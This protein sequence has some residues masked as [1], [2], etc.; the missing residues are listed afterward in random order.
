MKN[1]KH[2]IIL[3]VSFILIFSLLTI[4]AKSK[5]NKNLKSKYITFLNEVN[6]IMTKKEKSI[7]YALNTEIDR[8]EFIELFWAQRDPTPLTKVNEFKKK[9][10]NRLKYADLMFGRV[11]GKPGWAT[12]RGRYYLVLGKPNVIDKFDGAGKLYPTEVWFYNQKPEH[13][14]PPNFKLVFYRPYGTEYKLY[15]PNHDGPGALIGAFSG[16]ADDTYTAYE[17][18]K[19]WEPDLASSAISLI[20]SEKGVDNHTPPLANI[21]LIGNIQA[22]PQR[23]IDDKYVEMYYKL[24]YKVDV[25]VA[26]RYIKSKTTSF[27][28]YGR[29]KKM[30]FINFVIQP[31]KFSIEKYDEKYYT[32]LNI[33]F[34]LYEKKTGKK[35][36]TLNKDQYLPMSKNLIRK[37]KRKKI[38]IALKY[39]IIPG[40]GLKYLLYVKNLASKEYFM[41]EAEIVSPKAK[42]KPF[43][44]DMVLSNSFK[45][46]NKLSINRPF[47]LE[48]RNLFPS[49]GNIYR[50][51]DKP[52][53]S[54]IVNNPTTDIINA[55]ASIID[56][57]TNKK[58]LIENFIV[59][60]N[61]I[62]V[63]FVKLNADNNKFGYK[64]L[65]F[66]LENNS[67]IIETKTFKVLF[68]ALKNTHNKPL[69]ISVNFPEFTLSSMYYHYGSQ[70]YKLK[71]FTNAE[72]FL[73]KSLK[74]KKTKQAVLLKVELFYKG[75]Q[76]KEGI[77][78]LKTHI[79]NELSDKG[80]FLLFTGYIKDENYIEAKKSGNIL[81][82]RN[83]RDI[84]FLNMMGYMSIKNNNLS[85]AKLYFMN[86]L[87]LDK[88]QKEIK[89]KLD[90]LTKTK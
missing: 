5:K 11:E 83:Y 22:L 72:Y 73:N 88:N 79:K 33:L 85:D 31:E 63:F 20:P 40:K 47:Q 15:S 53:I 51:K 19:M 59:K 55:K 39:P 87:K 3:V 57:K 78:Y 34:N 62:S 56:K 36:F 2:I 14:V 66:E 84:R 17:Y 32:K 13:G 25:D 86:S 42:D 61:D 27:I 4:E 21:S 12:E 54:I 80:E 8:T 23:R 41:H 1:K 68:S 71:D 74:I 48:K 35:I 43:I 67:K 52:I 70:Y 65:I 24:K 90:E 10:H 81:L 69:H 26:S 7:F 64:E 37:I 49:I 82:N 58:T 38:N 29:D 6:P 18:I 76:F 16:A 28:T 46:I 75:K 9:Y 77:K 89:D 60:K 50:K 30:V 44:V 45:E